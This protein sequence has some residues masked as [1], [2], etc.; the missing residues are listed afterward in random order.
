MVA[1]AVSLSHRSGRD[2]DARLLLFIAAVQRDNDDQ[3]AIGHEG[4]AVWPG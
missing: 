3:G 2:D 4:N 1:A